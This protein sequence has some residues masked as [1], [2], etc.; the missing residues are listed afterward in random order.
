MGKILQNR[1]DATIEEIIDALK[2]DERIRSMR[3]QPAATTDVY[4]CSSS[5]HGSRQHRGRGCGTGCGGS[6]NNKENRWCTDCQSSTHNTEKCYYKPESNNKCHHENSE[7][8]TCYH[9]GESGHR[10]PNCLIKRRGEAAR[11]QAKRTKTSSSS[12]NFTP[13]SKEASNSTGY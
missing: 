7:D 10:S 11:E 3:T 4:Y 6:H 13:A 9:C 1:A 12:T 8:D 2:E 5:N